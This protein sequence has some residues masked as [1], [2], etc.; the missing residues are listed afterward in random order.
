ME[1]LLLEFIATLDTSLKRMMREMG[2]RSGFSR[3]TINQFH[4][5]DA[6]HSLNHPTIT[7]IAVHLNLTKA[8]V[9]AAVDKLVDLGYLTKTQSQE[10]RRSFH[11]SLTE[12]GEQLTAAK[13]QAL[14]TYGEFIR[15]ALSADEALQ[16]QAILTKLVAHFKQ[17]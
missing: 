16:F 9:T 13:H 10:D 4:Y 2:D 12:T 17:R 7:D 5:L 15:D 1:T 3:L 8:S 14:H 11:V 6:V